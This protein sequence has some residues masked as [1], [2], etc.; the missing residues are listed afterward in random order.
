MVPPTTRA[1]NQD[2]QGGTPS[3]QSA[4]SSPASGSAT[5]SDE[6]MLLRQLVDMVSKLSDRIDR[7]ENS[8]E[9]TTAAAAAAP[10]V[11][12]QGGAS[13]HVS[14]TQASGLQGREMSRIKPANPTRFDGHAENLHGWIRSV[15]RYMMLYG[16]SDDEFKLQIALQFVGTEVEKWLETQSDV[17]GW[18]EFKKR[19]RCFYEDTDAKTKA[20]D[21]IA[22]LVQTG[23]VRDYAEKFVSYAIAVDDMS[24]A[25][26]MRWFLRGLKP[27]VRAQ[28]DTVMHARQT[29][30]TWNDLKVWA[31]RA[32]ELIFA[33]RRRQVGQSSTLVGKPYA[34]ARP[35]RQHPG[36]KRG[37]TAYPYKLNNLMNNFRLSDGERDRHFRE[38]LCFMCHQPGHYQKDCPNRSNRNFSSEN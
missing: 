17:R 6:E 14:G 37:K 1:S 11:S 5:I 33:S 3:G 28:V 36:A 7:I 23:S 26:R 12:E 30:M 10:S 29:P 21:K 15:E 31:E 25:E 35:N 20:A 13:W 32:D 18:N 38:N 16:L 8:D 34:S 24:D 9:A 19:L 4:T 27:E 2:R 22:T